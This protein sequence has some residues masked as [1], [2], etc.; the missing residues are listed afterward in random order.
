MIGAIGNDSI[1]QIQIQGINNYIRVEE[2]PVTTVNTEANIGDIVKERYTTF[3]VV[4]KTPKMYKLRI[5]EEQITW[6]DI[7]LDP[8]Y[9]QNI[10]THYKYQKDVFSAENTSIFMKKK[11]SYDIVYTCDEVY[12]IYVH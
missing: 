8:I 2:K 9:K 7:S 10:E 3:Q 12:G 6:V 11:T 1:E 5:L 4:G